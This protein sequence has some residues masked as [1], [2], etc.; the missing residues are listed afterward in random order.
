MRHFGG[1]PPLR[2]GAGA[3]VI[4]IGNQIIQTTHNVFSR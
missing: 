4:N 3:A 2:T 1:A